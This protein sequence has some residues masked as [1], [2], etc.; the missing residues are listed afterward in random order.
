MILQRAVK[1]KQSQDV[2]SENECVGITF[3]TRVQINKRLLRG[4][5]A[6]DENFQ[7]MLIGK[8]KEVESFLGLLS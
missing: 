7:Y 8:D 1:R 5:M 2:S 6:K 4:G 3:T